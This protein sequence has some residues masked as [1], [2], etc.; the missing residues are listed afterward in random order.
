MD[1][2]LKSSPAGELQYQGRHVQGLLARNSALQ[3]CKLDQPGRG[4][5]CALLPG[6][7]W[8]PAAAECVLQGPRQHCRPRCLDSVLCHFVQK[9]VATLRLAL[10]IERKSEEELARKNLAHETTV[11]SLVS[12][13]AEQLL[14]LWETAVQGRR[15]GK[16]LPV[17][18]WV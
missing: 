18:L 8:E 15:K 17:C 14:A 12:D 11:E 10:D 2:R 6:C 9:E 3:A 1:T 5:T 4:R 7:R 16:L 13:G